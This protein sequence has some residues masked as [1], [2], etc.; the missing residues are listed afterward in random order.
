LLYFGAGGLGAHKIELSTANH[1]TSII[2]GSGA[3]PNKK[4]QRLLKTA[5]RLPAENRPK[6][7]FIIIGSRSHANPDL[8]KLVEEKRHEYGEVEFITAGS[9]LKICMVAEGKADMYPRLGPTCEWD[10]AAGQA[11]A[12]SAGAKLLDYK[13]GEPL[14]YNRPDLLNPWF[15]VRR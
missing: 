7:P 5:T 12:E 1:P 4:L 14:R 11:V 9:S 13:T 6:T 8:K 15:V 3:D 2:D 10:T